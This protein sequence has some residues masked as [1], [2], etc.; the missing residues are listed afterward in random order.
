MPADFAAHRDAIF[1]AFEH[2]SAGRD[3]HVRDNLQFIG[4]SSPFLE[5]KLLCRGFVAY[6]Q[7]DDA[8]SL[9]NWKRLTPMRM[10]AHLAAPFR[11]VIDPAYRD[12]LTPEVRERLLKKMDC[13]HGNVITLTL[14]SQELPCRQASA[15]TSVSQG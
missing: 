5:W 4:L 10:T 2:L 6:Y 3:S 8:R 12:A 7:L 14:A 11:A 1:R 9:E 15:S 13:V